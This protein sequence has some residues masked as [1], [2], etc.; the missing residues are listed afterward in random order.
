MIRV[1]FNPAVRA[2]MLCLAVIVVQ[3]V[4]ARADL[5]A[6]T[7]AFL[8][9][10]CFDCHDSD[11]HESGL[12]LEKLHYDLDDP[13]IFRTWVK[14]YDKIN[15]GKMPPPKVERPPHG[16]TTAALLRGTSTRR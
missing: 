16:E 8:K 7:K 4:V 15:A 9:S 10:Y 3:P 1:I 5:P 11:T 12:D 2:A 6:S 14:V 13:T